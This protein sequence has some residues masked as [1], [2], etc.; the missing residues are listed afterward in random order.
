MIPYKSVYKNHLNQGG[1][2]NNFDVFS[3]VSYCFNNIK[4][5]PSLKKDKPKPEEIEIN[6]CLIL[7]TLYYSIEH[8]EDYN[9]A[10]G[11]IGLNKEINEM[12]PKESLIHILAYQKNPECEANPLKQKKIQILYEKDFDL[13]DK[14]VD[15]SKN[16]NSESFMNPK[17]ISYVF[18]Y[19]ENESMNFRENK[20][21]DA[22]TEFLQMRIILSNN[23]VKGWCFLIDEDNI[24]I[25]DITA[26]LKQTF[27]NIDIIED[28]EDLEMRFENDPDAL[29]Y[30]YWILG[31]IKIDDIDK[32]MECFDRSLEIAK[33]QF[34]VKSREVFLLK[35]EKFMIDDDEETKAITL[36]D[37]LRETQ[38][39]FLETEEN[40]AE[41]NDD[42]EYPGRIDHYGFYDDEIEGPPQGDEEEFNMNSD[43]NLN[44]K[45]NIQAIDKI[46]FAKLILSQE[47]IS[48]RS[49]EKAREILENNPYNKERLAH[50]YFKIAESM[51]EIIDERT[52]YGNFFGDQKLEI[53]SLKGVEK[54]LYKCYDILVEGFG[55]YHFYIIEV[56]FEMKRLQKRLKNYPEAY[57]FF[58]LALKILKIYQ[59]EEDHRVKKNLKRMK[60]KPWVQLAALSYSTY[61]IKKN[62]KLRKALKRKEILHDIVEKLL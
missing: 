53:F 14:K 52:S 24:D 54:Y 35:Y 15:L 32:A 2:I 3:L 43:L 10:L 20:Q 19:F 33:K 26:Y 50:C 12:Y 7:Q 31:K 30:V 47:N 51:L 23:E 5:N 9:Y 58:S 48:Y 37:L 17:E 16:K 22:F 27:N 25:D 11:L 18:D 49:F 38:T 34:G 6:G 56:A 41:N 28:R 62:E 61:A 55:K 57:K 42:D 45:Q 36:R 46:F 60:E 13:L 8:D 1:D 4:P 29:F 59:F 40:K 21:S 44:E 39:K